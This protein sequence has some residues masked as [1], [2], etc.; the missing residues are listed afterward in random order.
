MLWFSVVSKCII[1]IPASVLTGIN[2]NKAAQAL[3]LVIKRYYPEPIVKEYE[4]M[5]NQDGDTIVNALESS[6]MLVS[7]YS[8]EFAQDMQKISSMSKLLYTVMAFYSNFLMIM[9]QF[10]NYEANTQTYLDFKLNLPVTLPK[11]DNSMSVVDI[12]ITVFW[13]WWAFVRPAKD[14]GVTNYYKWAIK[15][16]PQLRSH[17]CLSD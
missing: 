6:R 7:I 13:F 10:D 16:Y 3:G 5:W 15:A 9:Y 14:D 17:G 12:V 8:K 11:T 1:E 2:W 4:K